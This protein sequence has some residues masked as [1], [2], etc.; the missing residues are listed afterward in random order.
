MDCFVASA[1]RNDGNTQLRIPPP[2]MRL[3]VV[4]CFNSSL[5]CRRTADYAVVATIVVAGQSSQNT[6]ARRKVMSSTPLN[7]RTLLTI[8]GGS[9]VTP[10][11]PDTACSQ[12]AWPARTV[13]YV[14]GFPAGGA[15][16]TLSR[17]LCQKMSELSGQSFVVENRA[18]AG[19]VLGADAVAKAPPDGYT[20]GLG[21]I[22]QNVLAIGS[23][24]KLP[25]DAVGDFTFIGGMWQLPN[26]LTA[27]KD[28]FS[29]DLKELLAA[30]KKEPRKY[31]YA[32]AGFGTTLHLSGEMMN[33][34]AGVEVTHIPY[35]G[36]GPALTDLL[37]GRVDMLFDN[38]PGSLPS[39]RAG[40]V[41]PVA[42]TSKTRIPELPDV[43]AFAEVLPGYEMTSWT[44]MI[45]P[46]NMKADLVAQ[47]NALTVKALA[48]PA[49]KA[50]YS[51]LGATPWPT[52]PAEIKAF[53]DSEEARLLPILKAA[54]IKPE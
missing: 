25:Y 37:G 23:Y 28:L 26:I 46:A 35:K 42:V 5:P 2:P 41:K 13:R 1:P 10:L 17:I 45:G 6:C 44:I 51:D 47:I 34:M 9:I 16:D 40:Q 18:G 21:G 49:L 20:V 39:V 3:R 15:T 54:G 29:S 12:E 19:G 32:S 36:A 11:L 43:P 30:F 8:L 48:D 50:R 31:T 38:L 14:N 33:S 27:R 7:R 53:R 22:A 4:A 52:S 24:A